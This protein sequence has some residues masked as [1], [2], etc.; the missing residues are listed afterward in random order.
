MSLPQTI[1]SG[2]SGG[3]PFILNVN[4]TKR[5]GF[6]STSSTKFGIKLSYP[7]LYASRVRLVSAT[8]PWTISVF[9]SNTTTANGKINNHIRFEDST[10]LA[11][12]CRIA[13]GTYNINDLMTE[14]K[15]QMEAVS[16]DIFTFTYDLT[17]LIL[18]ISSSAANFRLLFDDSSSPGGVNDTLWYEI[19]FDRVDTAISATQV[20]IR[21][22]Y[23]AGPPNFMISLNQLHRPI[24]DTSAF[25]FNFMVPVNVSNYGDIIHYIENSGYNSDYNIEVKNLT[26]LNVELTSDF[27]P[28]NNQGSDWGFVLAFE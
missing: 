18:T 8:I 12:D 16:P 23:L 20:G 19:G 26:Y 2:I 13:P 14:M 1:Y 24:S 6:P 15:T 10:A 17:T 9:N 21:S 28:I 11:V 5:D 25:T 22:V 4:S 3:K 7:V 27:G